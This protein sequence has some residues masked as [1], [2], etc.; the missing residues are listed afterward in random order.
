MGRSYFALGSIRTAM[1]ASEDQSTES[2]PT[3]VTA[4]HGSSRSRSVTSLKSV[5]EMDRWQADNAVEARLGGVGYRM[6]SMVRPLSRFARG[7]SR[8][9]NGVDLWNLGSGSVSCG[10]ICSVPLALMF[11]LSH[12]GG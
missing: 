1:S 10:S 4:T 7:M 3:S 6:V 5:S 12:D 8:A 9:G 11:G 2:P